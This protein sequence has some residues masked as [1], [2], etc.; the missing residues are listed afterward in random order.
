MELNGNIDE[1]SK[2]SESIVNGNYIKYII[3]LLLLLSPLVILM[4]IGFNAYKTNDSNLLSLI[5]ILT[6]ISIYIIGMAE[7]WLRKKYYNGG[8]LK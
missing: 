2:V 7:S 4:I 8:K 1:A 5:A 6:A 3:V